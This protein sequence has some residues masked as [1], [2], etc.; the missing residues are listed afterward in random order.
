[1]KS[2]VT[3]EQITKMAK[4][5]VEFK[6]H[7]AAYV[8]VNAMLIGIWG[9]TSNWHFG[10]HWAGFWPVWTL[11]FWGVGLAFHGVNAYNVGEHGIYAKEEEKL[12]Q[13]YR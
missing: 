8:I 5:R 4:A 12:R 2:T 6:Q 11:L 3:D 9:I 1:M 7:L 10:G 13:K